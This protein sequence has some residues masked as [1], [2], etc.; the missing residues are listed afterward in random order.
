MVVLVTVPNFEVKRILVDSGSAV[1]V[2]SWEAYQ[3]MGLKEQ[4]L[5]RVGP[6]YSFA[7]HLVEVKGSI[8]LPVTLGD[9]A[10]TTTEYVQFYVVDHSMPYNAFFKRPTMRM[11]R[12]IIAIFCTKV[13]FLTKIGVGFL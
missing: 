6:L 10:H 5:S 9:G 11:G 3:K 13:M 7:N 1:K 4:A 2:L 8:T 12:I